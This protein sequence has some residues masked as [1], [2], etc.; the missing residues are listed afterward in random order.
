M[1]LKCKPAC[2]PPILDTVF[3]STAYSY[4]LSGEYHKEVHSAHCGPF[5][6]VKRVPCT[7]NRC[8]MFWFFLILSHRHLHPGKQRPPRVHVLAGPL[9]ALGLPACLS[10]QLWSRPSTRDSAT[11]CLQPRALFLA[12]LTGPWCLRTHDRAVGIQ[13]VSALL[14]CPMSTHF[15][16]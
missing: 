3:L 10:Y 6:A 1:F 7:S 2:P 16:G 13:P 8:S 15:I 12:A 11:Q 14:Q 4:S 9:V 5:W